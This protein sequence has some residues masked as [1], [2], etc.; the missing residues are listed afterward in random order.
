VRLECNFF[1]GRPTPTGARVAAGEVRTAYIPARWKYD[2]SRP[3]VVWGHGHG[4]LHYA[5]PPGF[6][7]ALLTA[8]VHAGWAVVIPRAAGDSWGNDNAIESYGDA[9]AYAEA[10][11]SAGG[12]G[13]RVGAHLLYGYSMGALACCNF[14]RANPSKVAAILLS[15]PGI[16]RQ[17]L[18]DVNINGYGT[19]EIAAAYGG[20]G[21]VPT[22]RATHDPSFY[23]AVRGGHGGLRCCQWRDVAHGRLRPSPRAPPFAC[24]PRPLPGVRLMLLAASLSSIAYVLVVAVICVVALLVLLKLIDRF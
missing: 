1:E 15:A 3:V 6:G 18:Y 21:N 2:G 11:Q 22:T 19:A 24:V 10:P 4:Q 5:V 9:L 20:A 23:A 16:E 13:A 7:A 14:A 12:L 8:W 17:R